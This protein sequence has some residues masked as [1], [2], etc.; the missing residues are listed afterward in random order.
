MRR[1]GDSSHQLLVGV[2]L[3][4]LSQPHFTTLPSAKRYGK[5]NEAEY[6]RRTSENP[7]NANFVEFYEYELRRIL[8]PRSTVHTVGSNRPTYRREE[9]CPRE[10]SACSQ[11]YD[12]ENTT[13]PL[14]R[15]YG[16]GYTT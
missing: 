15:R 16:K 9:A 2:R 11:T 10:T 3:P 7:Q 8:I 1:Y 6:P 5:R 12:A 4:L 14:K 13:T